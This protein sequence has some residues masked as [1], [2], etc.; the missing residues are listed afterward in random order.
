[1]AVVEAP[2]ARPSEATKRVLRSTFMRHSKCVVPCDT[3]QRE[4]NCSER[5]TI[6]DFRGIDNRGEVFGQQFRGASKGVESEDGPGKA[7]RGEACLGASLKPVKTRS[8]DWLERRAETCF[9]PWSLAWTILAL[10]AF[11]RPTKLLTEH[12]S[13]IV[14]PSEIKDCATLAAVSLALRRVAGNN[15]FRVPHEG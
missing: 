6:F 10:N 3:T 12:L 14:N 8:H 4:R 2:A 15:A 9:A 5:R 13:S 1:M 7:P 11:G